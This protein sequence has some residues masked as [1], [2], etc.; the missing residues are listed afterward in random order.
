MFIKHYTAK[1]SEFLYSSS[2]ECEIFVKK[3]EKPQV[4]H[5][6]RNSNKN[7]LGN[8]SKLA[9][10]KW[11]FPRWIILPRRLIHELS[12]RCRVPG[13]YIHTHRVLYDSHIVLMALCMT[14]KVPLTLYLDGDLVQGP[15]GA[16]PPFNGSKTRT[17][18]DERLYLPYQNSFK[19][20]RSHKPRKI[21]YLKIS[22]F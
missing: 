1:T 16:V 19:I 11:L 6:S 13:C 7:L 20:H 5:M 2:L 10:T 12:S 18:P 21:L 15:T 14:E 3:M 22:W 17:G 4:E 9:Y 8:S